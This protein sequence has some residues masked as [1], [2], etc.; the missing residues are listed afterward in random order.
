MIHFPIPSGFCTVF[1]VSL[2]APLWLSACHQAPDGQKAT[3]VPVDVTLLAPG[4]DDAVSNRIAPVDPAPA[5]A[6]SMASNEAVPAAAVSSQEMKGEK[7]A[8]AVLA[9]WAGALERGDWAT[10]RAQW[11]HGG[12]DSGLD[13]KAFV[14]SYQKYQ[15]MT[16]SY[17]DGDVEGGAGSLY[18]EVPVTIYATL[19]DGR[20][21]HL[22][23]PVTL[24]RVNDVDGASPEDL[25]WHISQS[26]LEQRP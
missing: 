21:A 2:A 16:V 12:A 26:D 4:N 15:R 19:R 23:G 18:Y 5:P 25:V 20:E 1:A 14:R 9:A 3:T 8:R 11:G 10:A 6:N 17:G 13:P 22:T 24:R 7:G